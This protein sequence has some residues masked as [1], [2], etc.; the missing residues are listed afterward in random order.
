MVFGLALR[1][2]LHEWRLS[3]CLVL[4]LSAILA[5]MLVLF[6]LKH[7][8]V[9]T[10]R[11]RL[12]EDPAN[13]QILPVASGRFDPAWFRQ[14]A[15]RPEVGFVLPQTRAI[16]ASMFL[17]NTAES[18]RPLVTV[19]LVPSAPGDPLL[20]AQPAPTGT[21]QIVL[22]RSAAEKLGI[23]PGATLEGSLTR[24]VRGQSERA[25]Q[26]LTVAGVLPLASFDRDAAFVSL[27]LLVAAE[28]YRDGR[29]V[30]A[31]GWAGSAPLSAD[32]AFAGF[33]LYARSIDDVSG[34]R[35]R[36]QGQ[37]VEVR[38]RAAEIETVRALDRNLTA[39]FWIVAAIGVGGYALSLASS[40]W[41]NVDRKRREIAVLRLVGF[42]TPRCMLFPA[43]QAAMVALVGSALATAAYLA[44]AASVNRFFTTSLAEGE[45]ICQLAPQHLVYAAG[46]TLVLAV[47]ASGVGGLHA[48]RIQPSEALRDV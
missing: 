37:G 21:G 48:A 7:G 43:C 38:T 27:E 28:D 3:L 30:E 41:G 12:I 44:V 40:L 26:P 6:G 18:G 31:L 25:T 24:V 42:D 29:A 14:M 32:R 20:A 46:A 19:E 34:L 10:M 47:V 45:R 2:F 36:M 5:P 11:E 9:T 23:A 4:A 8:V 1:D 17:R 35:D 39:V 15:A 13:R 33:R 22:S 16:A